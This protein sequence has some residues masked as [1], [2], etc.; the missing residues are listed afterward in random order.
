MAH[1]EFVTKETYYI[2]NVC[3]SYSYGIGATLVKE[4]PHFKYLKI[5]MD[6]IFIVNERDPEFL[7]KWVH[8]MKPFIFVAMTNEST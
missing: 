4:V 8:L 6:L 3:D 1:L 2:Y 7:S 5:M